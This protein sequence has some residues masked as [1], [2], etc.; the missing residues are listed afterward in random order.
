MFDT[1]VGTINNILW[2]NLLIYL[3]L[4]V[5]VLFTW[6]LGFLQIRHFFHMF[7]LI[8]SSRKQGFDNDPDKNVN[9]GIS[10]FQA[11]CTSLAARV[12]TGNLAGVAI[13]I[14]LGGP[15]A[16]FWMWLIALLGMATAFA[17]SA[18]AQLYKEPTS[19]QSFRGGP[20]YYM[21]RGL[22]NPTMAL[23]FSICLFFG[24]GFIFSSVQSNSISDA[25]AASYGFTPLYTGIVITIV[26]AA[27]VMGGMRSIARFAEYVVPFMGLAYL[28]VALFVVFKNLQSIPEIFNQI[29]GS[30]F[31]WH[32]AGSGLLGAAMKQG[33][34]RGLYSNEAG[35]GSSPNAAATATPYPPH[36][37]SQAYI[38]MLG[39]AIDTL[40]ICSCT[41]FIILLNGGAQGEMEGITMTQHALAAHVGDWG[42][43][44]MS[45]AILFFGFTSIVA[46]YAY[47]NNNLSYVKLDHFYGRLFFTVCFLMMTLYGSV[48]TLPQVIALADLGMGLMTLVNVVALF[49]L[50]KT[51]I[52]LSQNYSQQLKKGEI[53]NYQLSNEEAQTLNLIPG[54]W[55]PDPSSK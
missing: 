42:D 36:P 17:E 28:L 25:F 55:S 15:G 41:A 19:D 16:I 4:V 11:L 9:R 48:A 26:A 47:A 29:I 14:S 5:G 27:I 51:V 54:V 52:S 31:G 49:L 45:L 20:A 35:M 44:F 53:P 12:G 34:T 18:L 13:A 46:N 43:D 6:R 7:H 38:Q 8:K 23:V 2:G 37:I 3:L 39:V 33:I 1:I 40:L 24:Y 10:S 50:S 30:A 22:K 21:A 32:E